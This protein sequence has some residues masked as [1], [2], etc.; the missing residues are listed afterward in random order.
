MITGNRF[1]K[2]VSCGAET[3]FLKTTRNWFPENH[4]VVPLDLEKSRAIRLHSLAMVNF[5]RSLTKKLGKNLQPKVWQ[6]GNLIRLT[7]HNPPMRPSSGDA[8]GIDWSLWFRFGSRYWGWGSVRSIARNDDLEIWIAG[9]GPFT[10]AEN[11][12]EIHPRI[13]ASSAELQSIKIRNSAP[14]PRNAAGKIT[15]RGSGTYVCELYYRFG[16][17][18]LASGKSVM[19]ATGYIPEGIYQIRELALEISP[20]GASRVEKLYGVPEW[21]SN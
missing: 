8:I 19:V 21:L 13:L 7:E 14:N 6:I 5:L 1:P 3:G 20:V 15:L 12:M 10:T 17:F 2:P 16:V 9:R 4:P 18:P 11:S